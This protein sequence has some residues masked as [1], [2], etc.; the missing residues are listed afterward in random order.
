MCAPGPATHMG[1]GTVLKALC[2][3]GSAVSWL[4]SRCC[5]SRCPHVPSCWPD[6]CFPSLCLAFTWFSLVAIP[7]GLGISSQRP[8]FL[9]FLF[10]LS[11]SL[12][13]AALLVTHL[14]LFCH[15]F[16]KL[17]RQTERR[18]KA[19]ITQGWPQRGGPVGRHTEPLYK[20]NFTCSDKPLHALLR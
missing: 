15:S 20:L 16:Q 12:S 10:D 19:Q 7:R 11:F 4:W 6:P 13:G 18:K 2:P 3:R 8:F 17:P 5:L 9:I 1:P 14:L